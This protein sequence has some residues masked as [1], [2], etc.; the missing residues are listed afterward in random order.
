M[1]GRYLV[2]NL[3]LIRRSSRVSKA[4]SLKRRSPPWHS[5]AVIDTESEDIETET[6][7]GLGRPIIVEEVSNANDATQCEASG[8]GR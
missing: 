8:C 2:M 6:D 3:Q 4:H 1:R 5:E 7:S